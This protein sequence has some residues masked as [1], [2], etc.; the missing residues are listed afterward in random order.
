[1]HLV[2]HSAVFLPLQSVASFNSTLPFDS[3]ESAGIFRGPTYVEN[4]V[5]HSTFE[6][7]RNEKEKPSA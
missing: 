5:G 6:R 2:L 3:E 4:L 7:R 1:M